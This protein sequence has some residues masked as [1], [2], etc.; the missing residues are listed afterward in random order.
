[1]VQLLTPHE[2]GLDMDDMVPYWS[3]LECVFTMVFEHMPLLQQLIYI[4]TIANDTLLFENRIYDD[5]VGKL[6][7]EWQ[8]KHVVP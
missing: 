2:V 5:D 8:Q 6:G 3:C 1:M 4:C 7:V